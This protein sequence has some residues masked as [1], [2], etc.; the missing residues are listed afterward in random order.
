VHKHWLTCFAVMGVPQEI[1]TDNG[2]TYTAASTARFLQTWGVTHT[3]GVPH[4]STGQAIIERAH[5][6]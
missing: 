4:N 1:K 2:P 5:R 6:T 3:F